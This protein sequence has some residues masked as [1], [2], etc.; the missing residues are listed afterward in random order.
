[1]YYD[2]ER[3][4]CMLHNITALASTALEQPMLELD[5]FSELTLPVLHPRHFQVVS[6]CFIAVLN[7]LF[8]D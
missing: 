2:Y 5:I 7:A 8:H 4:L 3:Q 6:F 1:M